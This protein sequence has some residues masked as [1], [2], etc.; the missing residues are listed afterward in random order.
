MNRCRIGC[1]ICAAFLL[2]MAGLTTASSA[3]Q[4][5][6]DQVR[7][8]LILDS[9]FGNPYDEVREALIKSLENDGYV[10]GRNLQTTL[11]VTGNDVAAGEDI[12]KQELGRRRYDVIFVGGTAATIS[13]KHVLYGNRR[14]A[15]VFAS[16][17]DP[18]GIGVI[19]DFV[20]PPVANFTGVCYPVPIKARF[21]FI[22][23]LL[24]KAR[25]FGLIYA[26]MPQSRS[27]NKWVQQLLDTDPEFKDIKVIFRSVP[28]V[29]GEHG[30]RLMAE[31]AARHVRALDAYVDAFIKPVDQ[32]G[33][34]RQFSELVY[35]TA[36][37]PLIGLVK[38][39]VMGQ[40]GATA[41]V[42]PSHQ[43]IG[44]QAARMIRD[45]FQGKRIADIPPEWPKEYGFAVDLP[46]A[47]QYGISV[48]VEILQMSGENI[49][50]GS[51]Q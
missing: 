16:P 17:T 42:Y 36:S 26:D 23:Q 37:K 39:D 35:K 45:L 46:K 5:A 20:G 15:V 12:L 33:T 8:L 44:R 38:D 49:I 28:L 43:R 22:R 29:T 13:A 41:V 48:P 32:M 10:E 21:R 25:V 27:Y 51:S 47:R 34:R 3:T 4:A 24:P 11:Q 6:E 31:T 19:K 40:W 7:H 18:V 14:Q 1:R 50:K 30:D 9:Q 2:L